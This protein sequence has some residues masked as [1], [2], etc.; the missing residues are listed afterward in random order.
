MTRGDRVG[1]ADLPVTVV[2][3]GLAAPV[4]VQDLLGAL[5]SGSLGR[6]MGAGARGPRLLDV[7]ASA[8]IPNN[9]TLVT[10][11]FDLRFRGSV[12]PLHSLRTGDRGQAF[13][14]GLNPA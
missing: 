3:D 9:M 5:L 11:H 13:R 14:D 10:G 6:Q 4:V 2:D 7:P 8:G 12:S 1:V